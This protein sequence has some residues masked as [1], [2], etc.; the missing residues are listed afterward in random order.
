MTKFI[1][2]SK[3]ACH[4]VF[5][6]SECVDHWSF[7]VNHHYG[8]DSMTVVKSPQHEFPVWFK[9]GSFRVLPPLWA[10]KRQPCRTYMSNCDTW[11][12]LLSSRVKDSLF[13][14][15]MSQ[16]LA[17]IRAANIKVSRFTWP[18][19]CHARTETDC[20]W[21]KISVTSDWLQMT[22]SFKTAQLAEY[23]IIS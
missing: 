11:Q 2:D 17:S 22:V 12:C 21:G 1:I 14:H 15:L 7:A 5:H 6:R 4:L 13:F 8:I 23:C 20:I 3:A 18:L 9:A 19:R 10:C 16:H